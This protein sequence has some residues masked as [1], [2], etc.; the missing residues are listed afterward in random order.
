MGHAGFSSPDFS[1]EKPRRV[2]HPHLWEIAEK[3]EAG[4]KQSTAQSKAAPPVETHYS[5]NR[6]ATEM[7]RA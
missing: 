1:R 3:A 7:I 5:C 2:R 4:G 6:D